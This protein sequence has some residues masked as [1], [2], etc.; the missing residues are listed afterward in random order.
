MCKSLVRR[1]FER[2]TEK[3]NAFPEKR[4]GLVVGRKSR[5]NNC[6]CYENY[7]TF[8]SLWNIQNIRTCY[9]LHNCVLH[10]WNLM[11]QTVTDLTR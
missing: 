2:T 5:L 1:R 10:S 4:G 3:C 9:L 11:P 7:Y 8:I 6:R